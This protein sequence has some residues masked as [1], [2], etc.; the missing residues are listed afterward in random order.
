[1]DKPSRTMIDKV[2]IFEQKIEEYFISCMPKEI[3][4]LGGN[5]FLSEHPLYRFNITEITEV[6]L[7][8]NNDKMIKLEIVL[9][10]S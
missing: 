4:E 9:L 5:S 1:M 10:L 6:I 2:T 8:L 3:Q 7:S